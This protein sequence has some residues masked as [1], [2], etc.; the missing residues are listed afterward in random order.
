M[1][2]KLQA[3]VQRLPICCSEALGECTPVECNFNKNND[4]KDYVHCVHKLQ[5][6][7]SEEN[8]SVCRQNVLANKFLLHVL[9]TQ[10]SNPLPVTKEERSCPDSFIWIDRPP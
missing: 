9:L 3:L 10:F 1:A 2:L 5:T 8:V 4:F 7:A 6:Q